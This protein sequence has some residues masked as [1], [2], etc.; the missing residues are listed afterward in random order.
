LR[1]WTRRFTM[2]I[3]AWWLRNSVVRSQ[4]NNRKTP[5]WTTPKWVR[6][7]PNSAT[8]AFSWQEDKDKTNKHTFELFLRP[9]IKF[10]LE[11]GLDLAYV[12][13]FGPNISARVQFW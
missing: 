2:I 10:G 3:S 4:R 13:G 5:K 1:P 7:C 11:S 9:Q 6:S 12:F 8:V